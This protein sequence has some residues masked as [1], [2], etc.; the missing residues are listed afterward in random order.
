MSVDGKKKNKGPKPKPRRGPYKKPAPP[1]PPVSKIIARD[2]KVT[3][4]VDPTPDISLSPL[5]ENRPKVKEV[6]RER[7][8]T[9]AEIKALGNLRLPPGL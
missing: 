1:E 3:L 9:E 5:S 6:K 4:A 7:E 8:P 2:V